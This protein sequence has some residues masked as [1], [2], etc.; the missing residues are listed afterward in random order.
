M[1]FVYVAIPFSDLKK[2]RN[3]YSLSTPIFKCVARWLV[4]KPFGL[5]LWVVTE[6]F[7]F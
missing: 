7:T 4:E 6:V 5:S 2:E 1:R 3:D